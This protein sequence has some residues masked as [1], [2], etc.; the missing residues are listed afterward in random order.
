[1]DPPDSMDNDSMRDN[2]VGVLK[3]IPPIENSDLVLGQYAEGD[4]KKSYVDD[5]T[6]PDNSKTATFAQWAMKIDNERWK[7]VP[8]LVKCGKG[9]AQSAFAK[10]QHLANPFLAHPV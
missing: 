9:E 4:G 5:E 2:K 10:D 8:V 1:M 7:G 6:V 3:S